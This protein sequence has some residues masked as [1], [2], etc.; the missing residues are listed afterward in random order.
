MEISLLS[1]KILRDLCTNSRSTVT[2]L[3]AKYGI[4]RKMVRSRITALEKEFGLKYTLELDYEKLGFLPLH[5]VK[6]RFLRRVRIEDLRSAFANDRLVQFAATTKGDFE[7]LVFILAKGSKEYFLWETTLW[8]SLA[9]YGIGTTSSEVTVAHLGFVPVNQKSIMAS[10]VGDIYK[11]MLAVLNENSRITMRELGKRVGIS[12]G[13]AKYHLR[14]LD[15]TG[16]VKRY[17]TI[18]TKPTMQYNI[19]YFMNYTIRENVLARVRNER[20]TM[21][22]TEPKEFPLLSEFQ[23]MFSTTGGEVSFTWATYNDYNDG[24]K[25]SVRTH[26]RIYKVD[27]PV[28]QC[29]R[30]ENV[31]VGLMPLRNLDQK[32]N[33]DLTLGRLGV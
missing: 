31:V 22:W 12:D 9:R 14:K 15:E 2:E 24:M 27:S 20:R 19:V 16:I 11:R 29:A 26:E 17:T 10:D 8:E 7:M 21:Y 4:T 25:R 18:V 6:I 5:I 33:Y 1:R 3:A 23:M 30:I 13:L 28:A 32:E